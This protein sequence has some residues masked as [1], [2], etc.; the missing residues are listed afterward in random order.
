VVHADKIRLGD[1]NV[2]V[3]EGKVDFTF[4]SDKNKKENFQP[5]DGE[6]VLRK[7]RGLTVTS[8]NYIGHDPTQFRHYGPMGQEFFAAFGHDGIGTIGSPTTSTSADM[9]AMLMIAVQTLAAAQTPELVTEEMMV[10]SPDA[11]VEIFVRNKRPA[12]MTTFRPERTVLFVHGATYPAHT[13]FDLKLDGKSWMI[14]K[15]AGSNPAPA[16]MND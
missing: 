3:I 9:A 11:G 5:V 7:L 1:D 16:T 10:E 13:S 14:G 12:A 8:W 2:E 4:T 15:V 6:E